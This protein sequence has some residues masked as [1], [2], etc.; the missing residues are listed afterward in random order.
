MESGVEI[1]VQHISNMTNLCISLCFRFLLGLISSVITTSSNSDYRNSSKILDNFSLKLLNGVDLTL[2]T[3]NPI[4]D[5]GLISLSYLPHAPDMESV[6][7][8]QE[9]LQNLIIGDKINKIIAVVLLSKVCLFGFLTSSS[10]TRLY[11]GWVPRLTPDNY[12][13]SRSHNTDMDPTS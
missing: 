13:C 1:Y 11:R 12:T 7:I 3:Q 9:S 2:S 6:G 8:S 5:M 10:T 4:S